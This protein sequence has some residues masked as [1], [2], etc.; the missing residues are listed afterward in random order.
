ML[1]RAFKISLVLITGFL[2]FVVAPAFAEV[3]PNYDIEQIGERT[4]KWTSHYD[5]IY[6]GSKWVNYLFWETSDSYHFESASFNFVLDKNDCSFQLRHPE[7]KNTE[8]EKYQ[9]VFYADGLQ[10]D[11]SCDIELNPSNNGYVI[12]TKK[13]SD[14]SEFKTMFEIS[15]TG[16]M[17]WTYE[18]T[19]TDLLSSK[20]YSIEEICKDCTN[21]KSDGDTRYFGGSYIFDTKNS[22]H[23]T[24]TDSRQVGSD[25]KIMFEDKTPRGFLGKTVIDPTVSLSS[26]TEDSHIR[27]SDDNNVCDASGS[28]L[29]TDGITTMSVRTQAA[30]DTVDC[31]LSVVEWPLAPLTAGS[32]INSVSIQ[33]DVASVTLPKNCAYIGLDA[34]PSTGSDGYVFS[35]VLDGT[36]LVGNDATCTTTGNNKNIDL[37]A[38]GKAYIQNKTSEGWAAIGIRHHDVTL[39]ASDHEQIISTSEDGAATPAP[40]LTIIYDLFPIEASYVFDNESVGD[41][42]KLT[43]TVEL[44]QATKT[45]ITA[46]KL[47]GDGET[48][49]VNSTIQNFTDNNYYPV[50]F[51]PFWLYMQNDTAVDFKVQTFFQNAT[52]HIDINSTVQTLSRDYNP[53]Y[54]PAVVPSQGDVNYTFPSSGG[55][56]VNRDKGGNTFQIECTCLNYAEAFA[57]Q[58]VGAVWNNDTSTG[59][60]QYT[61]PSGTFLTSCYNEDLLFVTSYPANSSAI[62]VSGTAIFDQ[63]GGFL[64]AP[65][66]LL[67]VLAIYSLG[68]GRNFPI[69]SVVAMSTIGVMGAL[70]LL[71]LSGQIWA[72]LMV[73]TGLSIFGVRKFF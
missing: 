66:A 6:D 17:E 16:F 1:R 18:I 47:K 46:I 39:D 8:I 26:P 12:N 69:I 50:T 53:N 54:F 23:G 25:Y 14:G 33:F 58:S 42:I 27:D 34:Q 21:Q 40:T 65:A 73:I 64:G 19:N 20:V 28:Y 15:A 11:S 55:L 59:F 45:N 35:D 48:L 70:G 2:V 32:L 5:R 62:L 37:G 44:T 63:L 31:R 36:V 13:M 30:A 67:V 57:N 49:I 68:T 41:I 71:V 4:Y 24:M 43:G 22:V 3:G 51:G 29:R 72:L 56:K 10:K 7:T 61:C 52:H 9:T 60:F 38:A